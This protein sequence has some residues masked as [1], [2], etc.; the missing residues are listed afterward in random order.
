[1]Q[2]QNDPDEAQIA[3]ARVAFVRTIWIAG[4]SVL[5]GFAVMAVLT[6]WI[7][8]LVT[9][10]PSGQ[11]MIMAA[12]IALTCSPMVVIAVRVVIARVNLADQVADSRQRR[13]DQ[14][15]RHRQLTSDVADALEMTGTEAELLHVVERAF[16]AVLP[17]RPVELLLADNSHAH[18]HRRAA[19]ASSTAGTGCGVGSPQDCPAARRAQVH[20]FPD[21]SAINACPKLAVRPLGRCA[22]VC[23]PVSVMGRTVGVIHTVAPI[24]TEVD[25]ETVKGLQSIANQAGTRLACIASWPRPKSI[26]D[27][28]G[29]ETGDRALRLFAEILRGNLCDDDLI[30]RRGGEE[31]A[32]IF[33]SDRLASA[34]GALERIRVE[35]RSAVLAAGL[36]VF[37]ASYGL[38][39]GPVRDELE[40]LLARADSAL[41]EAKRNGRDRVIVHE[42]GTPATE[43][44]MPA[45]GRAR[46]A[47]A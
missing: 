43:S 39:A 22:A 6:A 42:A 25:D 2:A 47:L 44:A 21:S 7:S 41:F 15:A 45:A 33:G 19:T 17:E 24:G 10:S 32:V 31:F 13:L 26:N 16:G 4:T 1:V 12:L 30:S 28:Y 40:V 38:V 8:A 23:V 5:I 29:H 3:A 36:P 37:T 18:L 11:R 14:E 34:A 35:L 27:T 46:I 9:N 20:R